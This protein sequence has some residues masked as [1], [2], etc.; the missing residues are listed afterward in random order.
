VKVALEV[1]GIDGTLWGDLKKFSG[2]VCNRYYHEIH[3]APMFTV[4]FG[5]GIGNREVRVCDTELDH[6]K[7]FSGF[8]EGTGVETTSEGVVGV[9]PRAASPSAV[10][11]DQD[12]PDWLGEWRDFDGTQAGMLSSNYD[13]DSWMENP[14]EE[15]GIYAADEDLSGWT[16]DEIFADSQWQETNLTLSH[17]TD[18]FS[19]P[20]P[21]PTMPSATEPL[22]YF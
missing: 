17:E 6:A 13:D 9:G 22:Q 15:L 4:D 1:L 21:G 10:A 16:F 5:G 2:L 8:G 20:Q 11:S 12:D 19:G 3:G 7:Q 18:N 14:Q